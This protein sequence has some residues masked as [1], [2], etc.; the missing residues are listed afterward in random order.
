VISRIGRKK[1][2]SML[3]HMKREDLVVLKELIEAGKVMPVVEKCYPLSQVSEAYRYLQTKHASGKLV[4]T[5]GR[6]AD[7]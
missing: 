5:W 7:M 2:T 6:S 1:I 3:A 4:V